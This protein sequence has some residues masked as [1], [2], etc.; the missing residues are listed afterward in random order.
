MAKDLILALDTSDRRC[1]LAINRN[2]ENLLDLSWDSGRSHTVQLMPW[3]DYAFKQLR[4]SKDSISAVAVTT[5]PG[6]FTAMR[7]GMATAK[8]ICKALGVPIIGVP[9]LLYAAWP[10]RYFCKHIVAC[11]VLG[12]GRLAAALYASEDGG[13]LSLQWCRSLSLQELAN[14]LD[15]LPYDRVL[16]CGDIPVELKESLKDSTRYLLLSPAESSRRLAVLAE[17]AWQRF[18]LGSV[19]NPATL[20]A[21]YLDRK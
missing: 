17:I 6:S 18:R 3:L 14:E 21:E 15:S 20:Q 1:G 2:G 4:L 7:V 8:G 19:D 5:G 10:Y 16:L 13:N 11:L 12:R 9:T